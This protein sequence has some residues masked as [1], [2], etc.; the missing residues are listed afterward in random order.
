MAENDNVVEVE[1]ESSSVDEVKRSDKGERIH[2]DHRAS[3]YFFGR[4]SKFFMSISIPLF[5]V[6]LGLGLSFSILFSETPKDMVRLALMCTFWAL[7]GLALVGIGLGLLFRFIMR[8]LK[9]RD[10]NF[11]ESVRLDDVYE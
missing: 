4:L 5:F 10:P 7:M 2:G 9:R 8:S 6:F 3:I 1:V 11:E